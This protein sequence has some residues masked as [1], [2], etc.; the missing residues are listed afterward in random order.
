MAATTSSPFTPLQRFLRLLSVDSRE[1]GYLYIYSIFNGLINLSL[2]LG[3][4]AIIGIIAGGQISASWNMLVIIV[5][6]GIIISGGLQ[7]MQLAISEI[8]Q[9]RIFVKA[10][11][12]FAFRI[13]RLRLETLDKQ[14]LPELM[15]RFFDTLSL[16][17]GLSKVLLDFSASA[18]QIIFGLIVISFY[19]PFFIF[20]SVMV[21]GALLLLLYVIA[22][23]GLQTSLKESSYKYEVAHWLEEVARTLNTFKLHGDSRLPMDN[24]DAIVV[25]YL[26]ARK[27]HFGILMLQY[28][29]AIGFKTII[30]AGLLVLGSLLVINNQINI[31]QFVASE[32]III[33]I[34]NSAE[35]LVLSMEVIYDV[36]TA[37]EKLAIVTDLPLENN[38]GIDFN[39]VDTGKGI[40]LQ[41]NNLSYRYPHAEGYILKNLNFNIASGERICISG[42][43][44]SGKSTLSQVLASLYTHYEGTVTYNGVPVKNLN[45]SSLR[46]KI[47]DYCPQEEIFMGTILDNITMGNTQIDMKQVI[48]T[49]EIF[50]LADFVKNLPEGYLTHITPEGRTLPKSVVKKI[51]LTRSVITQPRLLIM[52]NPTEELEAAE[53]TRILQYLIHPQHNWTLVLVSNSA[54]IA[55]V[56]QR[57]IVMKNG[58]IIDTSTYSNAQQ[59]PYFYEVFQS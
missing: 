12:E 32:I 18:L 14:Y 45:T 15:N 57:I 42:Y 43:N 10:S 55:E 52:E 58:E 34:M 28:A 36:L 26:Q 31:G 33:L 7:I 8:L 11:L 20:F 27:K 40:T 4:Q 46:T 23:Q 38:D 48:A 29:G 2:P 59:K 22:P 17:K 54:K 21:L 9:Q 16:Q 41:V 6:V 51:I 37:V 50:G 1:I 5:T 49:A 56:C 44:N 39:K 13:P 19:H 35:K 53:Q 30:T 3:I 25:K 47:G 24:T